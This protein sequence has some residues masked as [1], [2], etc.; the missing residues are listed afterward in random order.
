MKAC[1]FS[2]G[3]PETMQTW[4]GTQEEWEKK[5]STDAAHRANEMAR[6]ILADAPDTLIDPALD[7]ELLN[8]MEFE[9][10]NS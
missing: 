4:W 10:K 2:T 8:Y 9:S 7:Q 6:Q 5:G 1:G 3:S